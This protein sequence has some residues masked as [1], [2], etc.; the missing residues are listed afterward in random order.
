MITVS[1]WLRLA[2]G[3]YDCLSWLCRCCQ[4]TIVPRSPQISETVNWQHRERKL[5]DELPDHEVWG[6]NGYF[7]GILMIAWR[8]AFGSIN[9]GHQA[10]SSDEL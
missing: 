4:G 7:L 2:L 9:A 8:T 6:Y 3:G 5:N 1:G 10:I